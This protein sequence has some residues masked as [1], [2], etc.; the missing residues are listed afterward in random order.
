[1]EHINIRTTQEVPLP[2]KEDNRTFTNLKKKSPEKKESVS[3]SQELDEDAPIMDDY[4]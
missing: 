1:M 3:I 4:D 2:K